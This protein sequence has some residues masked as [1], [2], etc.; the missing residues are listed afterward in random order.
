[1]K[2]ELVMIGSELLLGETVDTNAT[3]L[4]GELAALGIDV[5]YKTT[6]G[7]NWFRL[8]HALSQALI[9]AD[10]VIT[11]GGLGPTMD[12]LTRETAASVFGRELVLDEQALSGLE[13]F[14]EQRGRVMTANNR[15]QAYLPQGARAIANEWGTAPGFILEGN[16]R[17]LISLPGVPKEMRGMFPATVAPYLTERRG[18]GSVIVSRTLHFSGIG[19]SAM[20]DAVKDILVNQTNPT[21]A[22]YASLGTVKLRI[23]AKAASRAECTELIEPM[24]QQLMQRLQPYFYG[25]DGILLEEAVGQELRKRGCSLALAESCTGGLLGHRITNASGSSDY[26]MAGFVT[27]SNEAKQTVLGVPAAVL[28]EFGAVSERTARAM[29][30]GARRVMGS[31]WGLAVTGIAGPTGG[32]DEKPVGTVHMA[33]A[34]P[35]GTHHERHLF[36]GERQQIKERTAT[37]ALDLLRRCLAKTSAA[38]D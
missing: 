30:E 3:Y 36:R 10:V 16:G 17:C 35:S 13:R 31:T 15:K 9:R 28:T 22:P 5:H 27:Y 11:G 24:E 18:E 25:R 6:V 1:M 4:A 37:A 2:A 20:E 23:T 14:F 33:A 21:V 38:N 26:F 19:E 8:M 34:G 7:D 29:A 32:S 12:D